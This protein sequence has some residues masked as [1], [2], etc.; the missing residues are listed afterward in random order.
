MQLLL[1]EEPQLGS[2]LAY[3]SPTGSGTRVR[4]PSIC[5]YRKEGEKMCPWAQVNGSHDS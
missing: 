3:S 5:G 1:Q 4:S 2:L